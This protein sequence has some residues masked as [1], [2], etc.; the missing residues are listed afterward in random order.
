M[1]P[2]A[3]ISL[4]NVPVITDNT[5]IGLSWEDGK[6]GGAA[7][8]NYDIFYAKKD[9]STFKLMESKYASKSYTTRLA[10]TEGQGYK[11]KVAARNIVGL[12]D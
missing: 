12:S 3:P 2:N 8:Q 4:K 7:I 9:E 11:F 10:L 1:K 5:K 6:D